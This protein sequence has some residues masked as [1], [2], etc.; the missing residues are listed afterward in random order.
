MFETGQ[1][2]FS[3]SQGYRKVSG[4]IHIYVISIHAFSVIKIILFTVMFIFI[5]KLQV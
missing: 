2:R 4:F 5:H 1:T 3:R